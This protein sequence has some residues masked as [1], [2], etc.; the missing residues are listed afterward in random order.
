MTT[1]K[2]PKPK[3]KQ[4]RYKSV[5]RQGTVSQCISDG[6]QELEGLKTEMEEWYNNIQGTPAENTNKFQTVE[7]AFNTLDGLDLDEP[8]VPED[9]QS[10][11]VNYMEQMVR[12]GRWGPSR[13]VRCS[14]ACAM[15]SAAADILRDFEPEEL[16]E[17]V[18]NDEHTDLQDLK[19]QGDEVADQLDSIT[20]DAEGIEFPGMYS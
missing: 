17:E 5:Q 18:N 7:E 1:E 10:L 19:A 16:D 15:L 8:D 2:A 14:N 6:I 9:L 12:S 13:A 4:G 11:P 3:K 20:G